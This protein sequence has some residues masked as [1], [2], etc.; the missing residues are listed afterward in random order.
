M[1]I[2]SKTL[3]SNKNDLDEIIKRLKKQNK[4]KDELNKLLKQKNEQNKLL[5]QKNEQNKLLEK[6]KDE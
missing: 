5:K 2:M 1:P 3:I 4:Q 6:Q